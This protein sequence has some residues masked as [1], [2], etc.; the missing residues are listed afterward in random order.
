MR[1]KLLLHAT[2]PVGSCLLALTAAFVLPTAS[3]EGEHSKT[4]QLEHEYGLASTYNIVALA[5]STGSSCQDVL[6][7]SLFTNHSCWG[8][9]TARWAISSHRLIDAGI[10]MGPLW[11][12][13]R[14]VSHNTA[15][16]SLHP[17]FFF[18]TPRPS[19]LRKQLRVQN[20]LRGGTFYKCRE[21]FALTESP[22]PVR[23]ML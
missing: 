21:C 8:F 13:S 22:C 18:L 23:K 7:T 9:Q 14:P 20:S 1:A 6:Q 17:I 5:I 16:I 10:I 15:S 3:L 2:L 4:G 19:R 11:P 12:G